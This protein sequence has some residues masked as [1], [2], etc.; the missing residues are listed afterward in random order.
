MARVALAAFL[1]ITPA[2]GVQLKKIGNRE[3]NFAYISLLM[4]EEAV[5][6]TTKLTDTMTEDEEKEYLK[7]HP[8]LKNTLEEE[9]LIPPGGHKAYGPDLIFKIDDQIRATGSK[10]PYVVITNDPRLYTDERLKDHPNMKLVKVGEDVS[11]LSFRGKVSLRNQLHV[12]KLS[13]YNMTQYDKLLSLDMDVIIQKNLDHIF[14]EYDTQ[15]GDKIWGMK[16]DFECTDLGQTNRGGD[17]W[18]SA[19]VLLQPRAGT[20]KEIMDFALANGKFWGDQ[21]LVQKFFTVKRQKPDL[22]PY[23]I[24][25]FQGC[26]KRMKLA[27]GGMTD[28]IHQR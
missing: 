18:N 28:I 5:P 15:N 8:A 17:Y 3:G 23:A 7:D 22:F 4:N 16:N 9:A 6:K 21:A 27:P 26:K 14:T 1:F 20:F 25:D 13:I 2:S 24:A 12:Q 19:V 11:F 10:Y